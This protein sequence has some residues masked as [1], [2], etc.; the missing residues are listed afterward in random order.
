MPR[1]VRLAP[2][3][4]QL[5]EGLAEDVLSHRLQDPLAEELVV[6]PN[7]PV[8][9]FVEGSLASRASTALL[10]LKV[11]PLPWLPEALADPWAQTRSASPLV[12]L[13]AA[14]EVLGATVRDPSPGAP[15][16]LLRTFQDLLAA[17]VR[18]D[19]VLAQ[20]AAELGPSRDGHTLRMFATWCR[21]LRDAGLP[22]P[23]EAWHEERIRVEARW[24]H[25]YGVM[26][27]EGLVADFVDRLASGPSAPL[28]RLWL[29]SPPP[30]EAFL[31]DYL[32]RH[33]RETHLAYAVPAQP[34]APTDWTRHLHVVACS[35]A[36]G[37][38]EEAARL[39][40]QLLEDPV[41][42]SRPERIGL[43]TWDWASYES[44][45]CHSLEEMGIPFRLLNARSATHHPA[46]QWLR[47]L[48]SLV[49]SEFPAAQVRELL[50]A[51][52]L[53]PPSPWTLPLV[54]EAAS[55]MASL[56]SCPL[57]SQ[58]YP[59]GRLLPSAP[60]AD[61]VQALVSELSFLA[62]LDQ[63]GAFARG[64]LQ[65][66]TRWT[67]QATFDPEA[68]LDPWVRD[69][70]SLTLL[71]AQDWG[72]AEGKAW[73][74]SC[75]DHLAFLS[76]PVEFRRGVVVG[77]V[78]RALGM[79]FSHVLVLGCH[80]GMFPAPVREDPFLSDAVRRRLRQDLGYPVA[81]RA[82]EPSRQAAAFHL[83]MTSATHRWVLYQHA[84]DHGAPRSPSL[85]LVRLL[86]DAL[87][88]ARVC[89]TD[90]TT[91]VHQVAGSDS[92]HLSARQVARLL[93]STDRSAALDDVERWLAPSYRRALLWARA[94]CRS[95]AAPEPSPYD[96]AC[97][98]DPGHL[99]T[100]LATADAWDRMAFCP[101][102]VW[103]REV[104]RIPEPQDLGGVREPG[105][106]DLGRI[107]HRSLQ[108]ALT[109]GV[110]YDPPEEASQAW[111]RAKEEYFSQDPRWLPGA[112][113]LFAQ[114]WEPWILEV[115]VRELERVAQRAST[116]PHLELKPEF[117]LEGVVRI[118]E[119]DLPVRLRLDRLE[120]ARE[121]RHLRWLAVV[122]YKLHADEAKASQDASR[123]QVFLYLE[124]VA[125]VFGQVPAME[126]V[127]A[128][129]GEWTVQE[130]QATPTARNL[131]RS[132]A[133][134]LYRCVRA[135]NWPM[136]A[137]DRCRTCP[138]VR[139]CRR[140]D[141]PVARKAHQLWQQVEEPL[142]AAD[143]ALKRSLD[144]SQGAS[145]HGDLG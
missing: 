59:V 56:G 24:I 116:I 126:I 44:A 43:L 57:S 15:R 128:S 95:R 68:V 125:G 9:R 97:E 8:A 21:L 84:D 88:H 81:V 35:G 30:D 143:R 10:N 112:V 141:Q 75:R 46:V 89:A 42:A 110:P 70:S 85:I 76:A 28:V 55:A 11:I 50:M 129:P 134:A 137:D 61:M 99:H 87:D 104:L 130:I 67:D 2:T 107:F 66:L 139:W 20:F 90:P 77:S 23:Y 16:A 101:H 102:Q 94:C 106:A 60:W 41:L 82:E 53:R 145:G 34:Q 117:K 51:P 132:K 14:E 7:A 38:A 114:R 98:L 69:V 122:D 49:G 91:R 33:V 63:A 29:P 45:L 109:H 79:V 18:D 52:F 100:V 103:L 72:R 58:A 86:G 36:E 96:V 93:V 138:W 48:L 119:T 78:D 4:P 120:L 27:W 47:V 1:E 71:E 32:T 74:R 118:Q 83:A 142:E 105:I 92:P 115:L 131:L 26:R 31:C 121:G 37:E 12:C 5:L 144:Q 136:R 123:L 127:Q 54:R 40:A 124:A 80:R 39:V 6:T 111:E 113:K 62:S 135:G 3:F 140:N 108:L 13:R 133:E 25:V 19:E 22:L 65:F 64:L 17:G 73:A